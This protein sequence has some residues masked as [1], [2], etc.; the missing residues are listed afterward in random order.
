MSDS[1]IINF[2]KNG[3]VYFF[4]EEDGASERA[5]YRVE[6]AMGEED[7]ADIIET[8]VDDEGI[9]CVFYDCSVLSEEEV[10]EKYA[11]GDYVTV[12]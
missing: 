12:I 8:E 9:I 5:Y 4:D 1:S 10:R 7:G 11:D 2:F 6:D 3:G